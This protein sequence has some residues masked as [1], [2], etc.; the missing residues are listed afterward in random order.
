LALLIPANTDSLC[1]SAMDFTHRK[2][3]T[4][5][6]QQ[7]LEVFLCQFFL[8]FLYVCLPFMDAGQLHQH[9]RLLFY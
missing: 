7:L 1:F 2:T 6:G 3:V 4:T 9:F 5:R 8:L